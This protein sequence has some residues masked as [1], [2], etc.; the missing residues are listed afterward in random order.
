MENRRKIL[1]IEI[2]PLALT[3]IIAV[4]TCL[5]TYFSYRTAVIA[6]GQE[7][8]EQRKEILEWV[9]MISDVMDRVE[10]MEEK[11]DSASS[12]SEDSSSNKP[13]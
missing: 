11:S 8:R 2:L 3:S 1:T 13:L 5:S 4:A 7:S 10:K 12:S 6:N 9:K